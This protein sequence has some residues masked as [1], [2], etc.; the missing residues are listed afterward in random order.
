V[1]SAAEI[2]RNEANERAEKVRRQFAGLMSAIQRAGER[3]TAYA[4]HLKH[5]L[6]V[7]RSYLPDLFHCYDVPNLPRTN[8]DLEQLFGSCRYQ[9]RRASG[10]RRGS[11][12]L[13]VRGQVRLVAAAGTRTVADIER[14]LKPR[15]ISQW[16]RLREAL[17]HRQHGRVL[18]RRFRQDSDAYLRRI[19]ANLLKPTLPA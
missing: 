6:K 9:Q 17:R 3:R 19:E 11:E 2:L 1:E 10:R 14:C 18:G 7:T 15:S 4:A 16:R 12:G 8:N 5:F 13:V